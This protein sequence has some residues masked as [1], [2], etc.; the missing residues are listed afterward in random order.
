MTRL[1]WEPSGSAIESGLARVV[2]YLPNGT[3]VPWSGVIGIDELDDSSLDTSHFYDGSRHRFSQRPGDYA[4]ML[5]AFSAPEGF[6]ERERF[7]LSFRVAY[8]NGYLIHLVYNGQVTP[9]SKAATSV[10]EKANPST[11]TWEITTT[12]EKIPGAI[13]GAHI[14]VD[15]NEAP[16]SGVR[17]LEEIIYGSSG[18]DARL[19]TPTEVVEIFEGLTAFR[20]TYNE[21]GTF[22]AVGP[23]TT[24]SVDEEAGEFKLSSPKAFFVKTPLYETKDVYL[25]SSHLP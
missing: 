5:E 22:T 4:V 1:T 15:T 8:G 17:D 10:H 7:G 2:L 3:A 19:P 12:A 23:E 21:D 14:F 9:S 6:S 11:F 20:I 16:S 13:G 18:L 24:I 25:I